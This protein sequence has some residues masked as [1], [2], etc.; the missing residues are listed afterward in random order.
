MLL[1][2]SLWFCR[3]T[4]NYIMFP[5]HH[6][7]T[8]ELFF[9]YFKRRPNRVC[10]RVCMFVRLCVSARVSMSCVCVYMSRRVGVGVC[11]RVGVSMFRRVLQPIG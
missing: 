2:H 3:G 4:W 11:G 7:C 10:V 8:L 1:D 9:E 6:T 5:P